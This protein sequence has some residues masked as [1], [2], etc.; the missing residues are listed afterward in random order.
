HGDP[1]KNEDG[2]M[3]KVVHINEDVSDN[4]AE[5]LKWGPKD[6]ID[7]TSGINEGSKNTAELVDADEIKKAIKPKKKKVDVLQNVTGETNQGSGNSTELVDVDATKKAAEQKTPKKILVRG[8]K[9]KEGAIQ[10]S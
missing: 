1:G 8:R 4:R 10:N 3:I 5:N 7:E 2:K 6:S 9:K